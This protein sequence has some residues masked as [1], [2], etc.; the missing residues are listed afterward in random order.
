[1]NTT[2]KIVTR[3]PLTELWRDD[4]FTTTSRVRWLTAEDIASLLRSGR[5]QFVVADIGASLRWIPAGECYD[6]WKRDLQLHLAAPD[7]KPSLDDGPDGYCYFASEWS[8]RDGAPIIVCE[9]HH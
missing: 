2:L 9:R 7:S 5:V 6:F 8:S 4:G 1:M 3:L